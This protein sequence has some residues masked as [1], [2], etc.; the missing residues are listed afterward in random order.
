MLAIGTESSPRT[1]VPAGC[2][3][4]ALWPNVGGTVA[5]PQLK[6]KMNEQMKLMHFRYTLWKIGRELRAQA[7]KIYVKT[8]NKQRRIFDTNGR[9]YCYVVRHSPLS[10]SRLWCCQACSH[11]ETVTPVTIEV[12]HSL[13][14][15]LM[16]TTGGR[17][18]E[19]VLLYPARIRPALRV[20][21]IFTKCH[22]R[23]I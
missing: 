21:P 5:N 19:H 8:V 6:L 13:R 3:P 4:Y 23:H 9:R 10:E 18:M 1:Q 7:C 20:Q 22:M 15:L 16:Y 2:L 14:V 17:F 12:N 11:I